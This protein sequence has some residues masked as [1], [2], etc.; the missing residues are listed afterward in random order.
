MYVWGLKHIVRSRNKPKILI[1]LF[2][3]GSA[4]LKPCNLF[5]IY[6]FEFHQS[7]SCTAAKFSKG[8]QLGFEA[9]WNSFPLKSLWKL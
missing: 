5:L 6:I 2:A 1:T 9:N 7:I 3:L 8:G 4:A